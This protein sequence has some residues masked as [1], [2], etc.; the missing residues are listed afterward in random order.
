M[1]TSLHIAASTMRNANTKV[2]MLANNL[3][4]V[5]TVGFKAQ[6]ASFQDLL[7]NQINQT[8]KVNLPGRITPLGFQTGHGV[9]MNEITRDMRMGNLTET[10][11]QHDIALAGPGMFQLLVPRAEAD[12]L[13]VNPQAM[14]AYDNDLY[15]YVFSRDGNFRVDARNGYNTLVDA[16]GYQVSDR[17]G[18]PIEFTKDVKNFTIDK[19]GNLFINDERLPYTQLML[20][21]FNNPQALEHAGNN[22]FVERKF[23]AGNYQ[24][25][26]NNPALL[27]N[28][29]FQQGYVESSNVDMIQ[30]MTE[31]IATQRMLQFGARAIQSTDTMMGL[32]NSIRS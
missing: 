7:Y 10:N 14:E 25:S 12:R 17:N 13:G 6:R 28:T 27:N 3:A 9:R 30:E 19:K 11:Q 15:G 16:R 26:A 24:N 23:V 29:Q 20:A 18:N 32:A 31:L 4:N 1:N 2:D 5:N 22:I 21:N 8:E